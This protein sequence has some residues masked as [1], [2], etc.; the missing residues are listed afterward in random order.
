MYG[1]FLLGY[2]SIS[3]SQ[4]KFAAYEEQIAKD[5]IRLCAGKRSLAPGFAKII[6][7][8]FLA[9]P[10]VVC[11]CTWV[12]EVLYEFMY[13]STIRDLDF[14]VETPLAR[15]FDEVCLVGEK[16]VSRLRVVT[17]GSH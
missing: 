16:F 1:A 15:V 3:P 12:V 6:R 5:I 11:E 7:D 2:I 9:L 14:L 17:C 8:A 4:L 10:D 13:L